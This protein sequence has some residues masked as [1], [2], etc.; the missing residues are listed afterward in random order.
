MV[1][2]IMERLK[3]DKDTRDTVILLVRWH[4]F[5]TDTEAITLSAVRRMVGNVGPE[6]IWELMDVRRCDRIGMGRPKASPYRL[7]KYESMVEEAMRDPASVKQLKL[8]AN[9]MIKDMGMKPGPRMGW[10]LHALLE[11]VLDDP[12]KNELEYQKEKAIKLSQL[13]DKELRE[14]GEAGKEKLSDI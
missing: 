11:E 8:N 4:M 7:R 5:F 2:A 3:F 12:T 6:R 13:S 9:I 10:I 14:L 1:K